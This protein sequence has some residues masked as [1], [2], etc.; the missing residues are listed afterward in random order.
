MAGRLGEAGF[1]RG[2]TSITEQRLLFYQQKLPG[3][4]MMGRVAV[5]TADIVVG[6]CGFGE[7]GLLPLFAVAAQ[8]RP[9]RLRRRHL[10]EAD[11]L[12]NVSA[13]GHVFRSRSMTGLAPMAAL[14]RRLKVRRAIEALGVN[15]FVTSLAGI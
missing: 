14:Q 13:A 2:V 8:A 6:M 12:G 9:V 1:C 4:G 7:V 3:F 11:D 15:I 5:D 10:L